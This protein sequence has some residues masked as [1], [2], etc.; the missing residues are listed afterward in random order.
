MKKYFFCNQYYYYYAYFY[1]L[2][3]LPL[4]YGT[5]HTWKQREVYPASRTNTSNLY[6]LHYPQFLGPGSWLPAWITDFKHLPH[7]RNTLTLYIYGHAKEAASQRGSSEEPC[8]GLCLRTV[9]SNIS[10]SSGFLCSLLP[11]WGREELFN[12]AQH[13]NIQMN[14]SCL[15]TVQSASTHRCADGGGEVSE[16][17]KHFWSFLGKQS[18]SSVGELFQT[19]NELPSYGHA[20]CWQR[21]ITAHHC[22]IIFTCGW[23]RRFSFP[24]ADGDRFTRT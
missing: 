21:V 2:Y 23:R 16:S 3:I 6:I 7:W 22:F 19:R 11:A 17:T 5:I 20:A 24:P 12:S 9:T 8:T 10:F 1:I 4:I 14:T 15:K 18:C 13:D